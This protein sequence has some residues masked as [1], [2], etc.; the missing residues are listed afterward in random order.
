MPD[1]N[2]GK[3]GGG[4]LE[5]P[6]S[7]SSSPKKTFASVLGKGL[8]PTMDNNVLEVV[9][10]KDT[11][12]SFNVS[13]IECFNLIRRLGLSQKPGVQVLGVQICPSGRGVIFIT[14]KKE[15]EIGKY[16]RYDVMEVTSTGIRAIL[17][18][19]ASKREVVVTLK[20]IHPNTSDVTVVSYLSKFGQVVS[21]KVL[22]S[23]F[24]EGPLQGMR[25]GDRCYKMEIKPDTDLGSYHVLDGQ[26]VSLRYPGQQQTCGRCLKS[27]KHCRGK[28]IAK[29]C[30]AEGGLKADFSDYIKEVWRKVG[31][32]PED[33][34]SRKLTEG[35]HSELVAQEGGEFTPAKVTSSIDKFT[36]ISLKNIPKDTDHG[37]IVELLIKSGLPESKKDFIRIN[38]KGTVTIRDLENEECLMMINNIHQKIHFGKKLYCN[39]VVPLTPV[40]QAQSDQNIGTPTSSTP[41]PCS[42]E[43]AVAA[44]T[45]DHEIVSPTVPTKHPTEESLRPAVAA[46]HPAHEMVSP[47][48]PAKPLTDESL[49]TAVAHPL[50]PVA[51]LHQDHDYQAGDPLV[52]SNLEKSGEPLPPSLHIEQAVPVKPTDTA[53]WSVR[54]IDWSCDTDD[55]FVRRHSISLSGRTP[56]RNSIAAEILDKPSQHLNSNKSL[57]TSIKDLQ[58]ALS[59]FNSCNSTLD[60]S[61]SSDCASD[62]HD[63]KN[64][65]P[66][67]LG[68][69]K[70]KKKS[71]RF[72]RGDFLKKLNTQQSPQ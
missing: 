59:D 3:P 27:S 36:G 48:A 42:V 24:S 71:K 55:H 15:I 34:D 17:V 29:R 7:E 65:N 35:A 38:A 50:E 13:E 33:K 49:R 68:K 18:K 47:A 58:E 2:L 44:L 41:P 45:P 70:R 54:D 51:V 8:A 4:V 40:K 53:D 19:P 1:P 63:L 66:V 32:T 10:E 57:L 60:S 6:G 72:E 31:Y 5:Q 26:R 9:L 46:L 16:C 43:L 56:P 64:S 20:G 61:A 14:L 12:G 37:L 52:H 62:T 25:N 21:T 22:H 11:R 69:K 39:G 67:S 23:V 28:G 30:E